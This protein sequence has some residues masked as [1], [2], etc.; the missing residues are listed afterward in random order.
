MKKSANDIVYVP[1]YIDDN[2]MIGDMATIDDGIEA[3]KGKGLVLKIVE[4]E[5]LV[6]TAPSN[7]EYGEEIQQASTGCLESQDSMYA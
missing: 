4:E 1:L 3:L 5:S 6:R 7:K 2:L